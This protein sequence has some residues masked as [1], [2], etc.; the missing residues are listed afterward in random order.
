MNVLLAVSVVLR[1]HTSYMVTHM[2]NSETV[3]T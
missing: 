2:N 3:G 1:Q